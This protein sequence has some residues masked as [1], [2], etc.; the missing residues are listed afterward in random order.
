MTV[1]SPFGAPVAPRR[2]PSWLVPAVVGGVV[3]VLLLTAVGQYNGLNDKEAAVEATAAQIEVVEQRRFDLIPNLVDAVERATN[4][5]QE[6][7]VEI[8]KARAAYRTAS[9]D[10]E[11]VSASN[12]VEA[13]LRGVLTLVESQPELRSI[14]VIRDLT[15]QLEGTENRI[16]VA[17]RDY[18]E[19]ATEFNRSLRS[20][21]TVLYAGA[22]GFDEKELYR[23]A[24]GADEAPRVGTS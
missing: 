6:V 17:R 19:A 5:E 13:G 9:S 2:R 22:L 8:A 3:L 14:E 21:P 4:Q 7:F 16:A 15:T 11:R 10:D 23:A 18:N 24:E 1:P 20:F 12:Q